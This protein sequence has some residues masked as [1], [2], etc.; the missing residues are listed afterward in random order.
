[1]QQ[2]LTPVNGL[3]VVSQSAR[4]SLAAGMP[5][6]LSV[7][8]INSLIV[9]RSFVRSFVLLSD[10]K[11]EIYVTTNSTP[12]ALSLTH[13]LTRSVIVFTVD[14]RSA[15]TKPYPQKH[16]HINSF[17]LSLLYL[18]EEQCHFF[19]LPPTTTPTLYKGL[20]KK[21]EWA[22]EELSTR[23]L[24]CGTTTSTMMMGLTTGKK[25]SRTKMKK[26]VKST[27]TQ[28]Q[29]AT[30]QSSNSS[31]GK[32]KRKKTKKHRIQTKSQINF[33]SHTKK[34]FFNPPRPRL[35]RSYEN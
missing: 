7:C 15:K 32:R 23:G 34:C 12:L 28:S 9:C 1:M 24:L 2:H 26:R 16:T 35:G 17:T 14:T 5:I 22:G 13:S 10:T 27:N 19:L 3:A 6:C 31:L 30:E 18:Y 11:E 25:P 20:W 8:P 21:V 33:S 29:R 4:A